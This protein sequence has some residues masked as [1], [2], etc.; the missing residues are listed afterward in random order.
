MLSG[1]KATRT[2]FP[3][4]GRGPSTSCDAWPTAPHGITPPSPHTA[5]CSQPSVWS[6][7]MTALGGA[8]GSIQTWANTSPPEG[9]A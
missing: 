2:H 1:L 8:A 9:P 7:I 5:R 4:S 6:W 3:A